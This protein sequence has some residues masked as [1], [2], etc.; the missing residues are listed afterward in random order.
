MSSQQGAPRS[1]LHLNSA[2]ALRCCGPESHRCRGGTDDFENSLGLESIGTWLSTYQ[3]SECGHK[4][5]YSRVDLIY[6][7]VALVPHHAHVS[8]HQAQKQA[9]AKGA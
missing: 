9:K 7:D 1:C 4:G 2:T 5:P 6:Q 8:C 3:C